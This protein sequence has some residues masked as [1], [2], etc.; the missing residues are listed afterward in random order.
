MTIALG[1]LELLAGILLILNA[2]ARFPRA[3]PAL[4]PAQIIHSRQAPH[5]Q[6][7]APNAQRQQSAR[8]IAQDLIAPP[9]L[10]VSDIERIEPRQ[11]LGEL[12]LAVPP[13]T[14]MPEDWPEIL[15]YR[16][17]A[18]SSAAFE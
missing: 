17:I 6:A 12:G 18:M 8:G 13:K 7:N 9:R 15:L 2:G 11:P 4:A 1:C 5:A 3:R 14:P 16:P 10:D